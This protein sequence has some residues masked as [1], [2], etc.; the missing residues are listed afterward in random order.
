MRLTVILL[1]ALLAAGAVTAQETVSILGT[2]YGT[3]NVRSGPDPRFEI[4]GQLDADDLVI[5]DGRESAATR[6]LHITFEDNLNGWIPSFMVVG[7]GDVSTLPILQTVYEGGAEVTV[8]AYGRVNVRTAPGIDSEVVGQLDVGDEAQAVARSNAQSDWL[9]IQL[10]VE[11]E[12]WVAYFTVT[13]TGDPSTLPI[14]V[15]DSSG[16]GLIP[17]SALIYT[18]FNARLHTEPNLTSPL[19]A[20]V[21]FSSEVTPIARTERGDWLYV[22]YQGMEGWGAARLFEIDAEAV[23]ALPVSIAPESTQVR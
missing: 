15:P 4:V 13:V 8:S 22:G 16:A 3:T 1:V 20:I 9:L 12:G 23:T 19:V 10:A 21:P 11:E 2:I 18:L 5:I 7:I 14:L 6:W 17:P